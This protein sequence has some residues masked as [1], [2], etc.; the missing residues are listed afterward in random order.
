MADGIL[1]TIEGVSIGHWT[2]AAARTGCTVILF[3]HPALAAVDVRGGAPGTRETDLLRPD[4]L[5][6]RADGL[7]LTG[8]SAFGLAAADGVLR[9]LT[10]R[11][12]GFPTPAGL[13]PIV[14][15]AVI[16]D[17]AVGSAIAPGPDD[18]YAACQAAGPLTSLVRGPVG[19]GTGATTGKIRPES[20]HQGGVG[21][22]QI[23][24]EGGSVTAI[25]V[26]NAFGQILDLT[27]GPAANQKP[28]RMAD[29]R[30]DV[31]A[32]GSVGGTLGTATT[33]GVIL[34]D[35]PTDHPTLMRCAAAAHDGFARV[36]YP[37]HTLLDGDLVF[38]AT[39]VEGSP[40]TIESLRISLA[41]EVATERAILD[42]VAAST[43]A[44]TPDKEV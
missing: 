44:P 33:L 10:E 15:A 19:A 24:W 9:F 31:I 36:I 12:R 39:L 11:E 2:D 18:G 43:A 38:A 22:G 8:G 29:P 32:T 27:S 37:C 17:L 20:V 13:V 1:R 14:P 21:I 40:T 4:Q 6:R 16:Y 3:E 42:A 30:F 28:D 41:T 34:I 35:A 23:G 5:V 25:A 7:L 26:V